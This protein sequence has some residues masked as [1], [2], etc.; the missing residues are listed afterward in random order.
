MNMWID[1]SVR[2]CVSVCGVCV[3]E[4]GGRHEGIELYQSTRP[5]LSE[6]Y[7]DTTHTHTHKL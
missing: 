1:K 6:Y 3:G 2:V 7:A 4:G 5:D